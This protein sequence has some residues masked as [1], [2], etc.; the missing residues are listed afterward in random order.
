MRKFCV[1]PGQ[2]LDQIWPVAGGTVAERVAAINAFAT[3]NDLVANVKDAGRGACFR[4]AKQ[5]L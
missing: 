3:A 4:R 5:S 1:I 2:K